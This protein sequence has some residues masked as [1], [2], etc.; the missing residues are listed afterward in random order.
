[1]RREPLAQ[2]EG[3][4]AHGGEVEP[5]VGI[6]VEDEPVRLVEAVDARAPDVVFERSHLHAG[7][8]AGELVDIEIDATLAVTLGDL[9]AFELAGDRLVAVLLEEALRARP[10]GTAHEAEETL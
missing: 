6:E 9:A 10:L 8:E 5:F 1:E 7:D 4:R 2:V 3:G